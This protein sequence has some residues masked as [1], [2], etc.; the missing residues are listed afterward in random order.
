MQ[1]I[2]IHHRHVHAP[3]KASHGV[4]GGTAE[5]SVP[6]AR[7]QPLWGRCSQF[8]LLKK[9]RPA[10]MGAQ[11]TRDAGQDASAVNDRSFD[12]QG[13]LRG[14]V[15]QGFR[16]RE[17]VSTSSKKGWRPVQENILKKMSL[18]S[19]P[20]G[21]PGMFLAS[22]PN[23]S[24]PRRR[25]RPFFLRLLQANLSPVASSIQPSSILTNRPNSQP[26]TTATRKRRIRRVFPLLG[27]KT[28]NGRRKYS[29]KVG[30]TQRQ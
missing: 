18:A 22:P 20:R 21:L 26:R 16:Y 15:H 25:S 2:E 14:L 4:V 23:P 7:C 1:I 8:V 6:P 27:K 3:K 19:R 11:V 13:N 24:R 9:N 17:N 30:A 5:N 10:V 12:D 28:Q 29:L